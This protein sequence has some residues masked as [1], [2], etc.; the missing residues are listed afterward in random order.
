MDV[1]GLDALAAIRELEQ[2]HRALPPTPSVA[3][4]D[5]VRDRHYAYLSF[6]ARARNSGR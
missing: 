1:D 6:R 5:G 3:R 2:A 4:G